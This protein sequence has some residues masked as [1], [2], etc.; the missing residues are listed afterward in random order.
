MKTKYFNDAV[1]GN[2]KILASYS[3]T[4]ELLRLY[5]PT[6]DNKQFLDYFETGV[7]IND[8]SLIYLHQDINNEYKQKYIENTNILSTEIKNTYFKLKIVQTDFVS[9][10]NNMLIKRYAFFNE[11]LIDLDVKFFIHSKLH[12]GENNYVGSKLIENGLTQYAH[13]FA[14]NIFSNKTNRSNHQLNDSGSNIQEG[15]IHDKDYIGMAPDASV[16]YDIGIIKAGEKKYLDIFVNVTANDENDIREEISKAKKIEVIKEQALVGA[17]WEKYLKK[18]DTFK[19]AAPRNLYEEKLQQI[20]Q[21]TILLFPLLVNS[22]TGGIS[23]A[24]EIDEERTK[25]GRYSYCWTRDAVFITKAM[26]ILGMKKETEKFYKTFCKMTQSADGKWEQ[27][28]YTD[29]R[30]APCWGYQVDETAS[31]IFGVYEHYK[32]VQD[33]KFLKDTL[34]MCEKANKFLHQYIEDLFNE[35][36]RLH[37]SYDLWEMHEGTNMYSISCIFA[38]FEAMDHIYDAIYSEYEENRIKQEQIRAEKKKIEEKL[39]RIKEYIIDNFYEEERK[40]FVR[41]LED[42]WIDVSMIGS[43]VPFHI[44][45]PK[46][47]K[48]MNTVETIDMTLRTYTGGYKRFENDNYMNGN[49]WTIATLWM[50]LYHIE[51]G[52]KTK[53][54]EELTYVVKTASENALIPEQVNNDTMSPAWVI[55][56]GWAHAMFIL[57]LD[58]LYRKEE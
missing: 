8:S 15:Y 6:R 29:G 33:K 9:I 18:H 41:N 52:E 54:R 14:L 17:Y 1:I 20:Y 51:K 10:K 30:L 23:A 2:D 28:F 39:L 37:V 36:H 16:C 55:G 21:R 4:G 57:A 56:L 58:K 3:K 45:T 31:V 19:F 53:A 48:V 11:N 47:K 42:K 44:F 25:C 40:S 49:P 46:E 35:E 26:D 34:K 38:A 27:R 22:E 5:Y 7:K 50:A 43:V 24:V 32:M 12:S 13:D